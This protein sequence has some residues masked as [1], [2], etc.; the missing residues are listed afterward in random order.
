MATIATLKAVIEQNEVCVGDTLTVLLRLD[1]EGDAI[2][3]QQ[4]SL[5]FDPSVLKLESITTGGTINRFWTRQPTLSDDGY[6]SWGG[7]MPTPGFDAKDGLLFKL[8]YSVLREG[9]TELIIGRDSVVLLNDGAGTPAT[10]ATSPLVLS[11]MPSTEKV[12]TTERE[13][14]GTILDTTPPEPF[15][16]VMAR[17]EL[18]YDNAPFAS[19]VTTDT[20]S[21]IAYY[22]AR[23]NGGQWTRTQSPY[24]LNNYDGL[25]VLE[26]RAVDAAGNERLASVSIDFGGYG[27]SWLW[28]LLPLAILIA[29]VVI[30]RKMRSMHS[31]KRESLTSRIDTPKVEYFGPINPDVS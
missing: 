6:I 30:Y 17:T 16:I 28:W 10:L 4:G 8:T 26:V 9:K 7:G 18:A 5:T 3:A 19:F 27:Y 13:L 14:P 22:E 1:V 24:V 29:A 15:Q 31:A 25:V 23:E 21:G 12:C 11:V 2:N 20:E